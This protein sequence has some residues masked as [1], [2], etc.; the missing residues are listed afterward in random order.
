MTRSTTVTDHSTLPLPPGRQGL[1]VVGH[2]LRYVRD[3]IALFEEVYAERG[4]V[5][6]I[7]ATG[8]RWT[9]LLG[10]DAAE[11]VFRNADH[12][13]ANGPGWSYLVGPFFDRGLMLLDGQEHLRHRRI[14]QQA[15]TADRIARSTDAMH[16]PVEDSL[17]TWT[18]TDGFAAYPALKELTLDLAVRLFMGGS[19]ATPERLAAVN[20][21]FVDC[22]QA[23]TSLV[24]LP[25]PGTRWRR[26]LRGRALLED[27][28]REHL[29]RARASEGD[30]LFSALCHARSEEGE[31]FSDTDVVN[32]L[33]FLLMAAHDTSTITLT[34]MMQH[35]GQHPEWQERCRA[36]VLALG[37][38]PSREDHAALPSLDLVMRES[39]RLVTPV[40]V[41]A[42]Q[43]V[44]ETSVLG[45]RIPAG[46]FVMTAPVFTH[47][48]PEVWRD[49]ER[50][51]PERFSP[52]R[53]EDKAHRYAWHPFGGGVHKCLGMHFGGA[54]V[55]TVMSHLLRRFT[56]SVD[57]GYVCPIDYT[58]LPYPSDG[59]PVDLAPRAVTPSRW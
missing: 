1:P 31:V 46:S 12:A 33:V 17:D 39:M 9:C 7:G 8:R 5:S 37:H 53:R 32:H 34:A 35:L 59:L 30:D 13:F 16:G 19:D 44:K 23:A 14:M 11:A 50:F 54:E 55:L 51:D 22:V 25:L 4:P 26:G 58:S 29:P 43:A 56:W 24:R 52:E 45:Y 20:R 18:P 2:T 48:S 49:P 6:W 57:P 47:H 40:P 42:R 36:E 27:F 3:P 28:L 38:R 10:P 15:F 41:V 21:A